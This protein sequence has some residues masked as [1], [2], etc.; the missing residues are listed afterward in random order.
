M[1]TS[2]FQALRVRFAVGKRTTGAFLVIN[3]VLS[4]ETPA[5]QVDVI[6]CGISISLPEHIPRWTGW[7]ANAAL[8]LF[9]LIV[10]LFVM[11]GQQGTMYAYTIM[12]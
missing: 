8:S 2:V 10:R 4:A 11:P 3:A 6:C 12:I 1:L 5:S 9:D 7:A